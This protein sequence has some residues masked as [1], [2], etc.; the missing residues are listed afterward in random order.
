MKIKGVVEDLKLNKKIKN[1]MIVEI[2][3]GLYLVLLCAA[4]G[5]FIFG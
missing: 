4:W 2:Y 3:L 5:Q 1:R